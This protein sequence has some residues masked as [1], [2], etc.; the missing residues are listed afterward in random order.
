[1]KKFKNALIALSFFVLTGVLVGGLILKD[2]N[3]SKKEDKDISIS[4]MK[5]SNGNFKDG[6]YF[7]E[8]EGYG[9][10]IKVK[11]IVKNGKMKDIKIISHNETPEYLANAEKV[12]KSILE[13]GNL[14]VDSVAG[15]TISSNAIKKA[16]ANALKDAVLDDSF[17]LA[18]K[19]DKA[20]TN[21]KQSLGFVLGT[22]VLTLLFIK[23]LAIFVFP[24]AFDKALFTAFIM[25]LLE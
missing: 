6:E 5:K 25:P 14:D 10:T 15:A 20:S 8:A 3:S 22:L 16:V 2:T 19:E 13:K 7:G 21:S 4:K 12:I 23:L 24:I 17:K 9:G 11:V 18:V 1:M